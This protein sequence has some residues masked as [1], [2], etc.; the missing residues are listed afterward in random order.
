M[1]DKLRFYN[2]LQL[3]KGIEETA[4]NKNKTV[5]KILLNISQFRFDSIRA[6]KSN[7][8]STNYLPI[9]SYLKDFPYNIKVNETLGQNRILGVNTPVFHL[10]LKNCT[11]VLQPQD[12]LLDK[13][14]LSHWGTTRIWLVVQDVNKVNRIVSKEVE[15]IRLTDPE[16]LTRWKVNCPTPLY[17]KS[18][19]VSTDFLDSKKIEYQIFKQE[20]GQLVYVPKGILCQV[21]D[22]GLNLS[23]SICVGSNIW[24]SYV[25]NKESQTLECKN[26]S[27]QCIQPN[28]PILKTKFFL[29]AYTTNI[30]DSNWV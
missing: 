26:D 21:M 16:P 7:N 23:E 29:P 24:N 12:S 18:V 4:E 9:T 28:Y 19:A 15:R 14:N 3:L 30:F 2:Y 1:H 17:H 25:S 13:C 5:H 8:F 22:V 27:F 11:S 6:V 20:P 10:S